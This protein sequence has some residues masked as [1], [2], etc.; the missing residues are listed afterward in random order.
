MSKKEGDLTTC[1]S[2]LT[3]LLFF[4]QQLVDLPCIVE[5]H[6]TLDCKSLYKTADVCQVHNDICIYSLGNHQ[7]D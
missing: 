7:G 4:S 5:S 6:K 3:N 1:S 2:Q